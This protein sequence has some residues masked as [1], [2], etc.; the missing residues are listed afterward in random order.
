MFCFQFKEWLHSIFTGAHF[1]FCLEPLI[2]T[3]EW[4]YD[5]ILERSCEDQTTEHKG[6]TQT[7][8][9]V[10]LNLWVG[11]PLRG[12]ISDIEITVM[13]LATHT[14]PLPFLNGFPNASCESIELHMFAFP[15]RLSGQISRLGN[16]SGVGIAMRCV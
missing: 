12:H 8:V 15:P 9:T 11:T 3:V 6:K 7:A 5:T 13:K 14:C 10:V 2:L 16:F 1:L 4:S